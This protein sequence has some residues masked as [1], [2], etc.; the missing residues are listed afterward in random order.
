MATFPRKES[1]PIAG[2]DLVTHAEA[3]TEARE[4]A[5]AAAEAA[6]IPLV[7]KGAAESV[8]TLDEAT[9]LPEAQLPSSVA[10]GS[11]PSLT[12]Q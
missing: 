8:A 9:K 2:A 5:Q 11:R 12:Q 10:L 1:D 7:E 6:S 4:A 3:E